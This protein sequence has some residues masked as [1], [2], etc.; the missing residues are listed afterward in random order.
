MRISSAELSNMV[1]GDEI[2]GYIHVDSP[3][4]V[5]CMH[6]TRVKEQ[7][8]NISPSFPSFYS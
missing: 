8:T 6:V 4:K 7:E 1:P 2:K 5:E 3:C